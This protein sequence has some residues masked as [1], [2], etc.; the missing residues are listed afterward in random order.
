MFHL[1]YIFYLVNKDSK[2]ESKI[3]L[4][5]TNNVIYLFIHSHFSLKKLFNFKLLYFQ[6]LYLL[7]IIFLK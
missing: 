6:F 1:V 4:S 5:G 3:S 2:T 7:I